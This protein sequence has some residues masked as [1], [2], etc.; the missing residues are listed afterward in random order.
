MNTP[1]IEQKREFLDEVKSYVKA[2]SFINLYKSLFT[3]KKA[4][5]AKKQLSR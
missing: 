4:T 2:R 1:H 3:C 5:L